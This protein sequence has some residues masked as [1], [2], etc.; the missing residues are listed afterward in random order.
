MTVLNRLTVLA[1]QS[2]TTERSVE[3]DVPADIKSSHQKWL[4]Q[5]NCAQAVLNNT[6]VRFQVTVETW[7][8]VGWDF[9]CGFVFQGGPNQ[10]RGGSTTEVPGVFNPAHE[11]DGKRIRLTVR[12]LSGTPSLGLDIEGK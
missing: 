1:R 7:N 11:I 6:G 12:T 5:A 3:F 8:G 10:G 2:T 4:L 9:Y